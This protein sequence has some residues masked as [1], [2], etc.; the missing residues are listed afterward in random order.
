[1]RTLVIAPHPDDETL[2][3]GG[4]ISRLVSSGSKV[5]ILTI[6]GH[7]PPL[8]KQIDFEITLN[9]ALEAYKELGIED[10]EFSK[11][12]ATFVHQ[13]PVAKLNGLI[14][15]QKPDI[16]ICPSSHTK[17]TLLKLF[18]IRPERIYVIPLGSIFNFIDL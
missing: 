18:K 8:Y 14:S 3:L 16:I 9:E 1:M 12:P 4:T 5:S 11:I 2:A 15:I 17:E 13:Q 10:Y 7:L 6:S